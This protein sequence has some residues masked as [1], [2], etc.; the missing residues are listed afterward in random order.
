M[1]L[2]LLS[3]KT[4]QFN[5]SCFERR[6]QLKGWKKLLPNL[7]RGDFST[8]FGDI[9][10]KMSFPNLGKK[11]NLRQIRIWQPCNYVVVYCD[12]INFNHKVYFL[13]HEQMA[14]EIKTMGSAAHGTSQANKYNLNIEES[15]T[16]SIDNIWVSKYFN[17]ELKKFI[18]SDL[19]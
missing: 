11:I 6:L 18:F 17:L 15:V 4:A 9:E 16:L 19:N 14:Q 3:N 13:S 12:Y 5:A 2:L 10:L 7:N 1:F 8:N